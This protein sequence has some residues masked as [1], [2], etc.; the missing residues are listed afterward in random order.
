MSFDSN[1]F[2]FSSAASSEDQGPKSR[3]EMM[4]GPPHMT[5]NASNASASPGP[6]HT[7]GHPDE[8][9]EINSPQ[10]WPRPPASPV[11][12]NSHVPP[13]AESYRSTKVNFPRLKFYIEIN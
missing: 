10:S 8:F 5:P 11:F 3:K 7:P 2:S 1:N 6:G 13:T 4:Y 9:G 12:S